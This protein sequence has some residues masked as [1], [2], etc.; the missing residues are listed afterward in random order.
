LVDRGPRFHGVTFSRD[1]NYIYFL[2]S[3][4][5]DPNLNDLYSMPVMGGAIR[6]VMED[7]DSPITFSPDGKEFGFERGVPDR[8]ALELRIANSDGS[9]ERL[10]A[11]FQDGDIRSSQPGPSWSSDGRSIVLPVPILGKERHWICASVSVTDGKIEQ[12]YSG[13]DSLGRPV[14]LSGDQLLIPRYSRS[15]ERTQLWAISYPDG[16]ARQFTNDLVNYDPPLDVTSDR[17]SVVAVAS[18]IASNIW[19]AGAANLSTPKQVS[20][21]QP[22]M[23]NVTETADGG[24]LS[25]G[26]DG[27]LWKL[28]SE[29]NK[30]QQFNEASEVEWLSRCGPFV[31]FA[32]LGPDAVTITRANA[33]GAGQIKLITGNVRYPACSADG[34]HVFYVTGHYPH[35]VWRMP[36][37]GGPSKEI[38][39][40]ESGGVEG[41]LDI[42]P[43]GE[44]ISYPTEESSPGW[45]IDIRLAAGGAPFRTFKVP[46]GVTRVHWSPSG[47]ALQYLLTQHGVTNIWEQH[48]EGGEAKQLT[49]FSSGQIFDFTWSF[50][51]RR[52][53]LARG[54]MTSDIVLFSNLR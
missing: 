53:Y 23:V 11:E 28:S 34:K 17:H 44:L 43:N 31:L 22:P 39:T 47:T 20:S 1:Q 13:P 51:H 29:G 32:Q 21:G 6:R 36:S 37:E 35:K 4:K 10:L 41:P 30:R 24:I 54:D 46:A 38:A 5:E 40:V 45:R 33:D 49:A 42:S 26:R 19:V 16:R 27:R 15:Y 14:W 12:M 3:N 7:V 18:E 48:L 52:L 8:N 9:R 2:R 50:D 25:L